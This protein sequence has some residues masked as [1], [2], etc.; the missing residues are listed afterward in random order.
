MIELIQQ[1]LDSYTASNPVEEEQAT[2]E[3]L[4]EIALYSLW[5]AGFFE[6]AAFQGGTS[7]RILH[8]LPRF[9]ED[10]DFILKEPDLNFKWS[11]YLDQLLEGLQEFGLQSEALDKSRMN[12][13]IKKA[14][15]KDNSVSNQLDLSF[16]HGHPDKKL[17][18]KL[19]I[20]VNPP[21]GS[22]FE[23]SYLDF[24]LDFEVCHQDLSSNFSLKVH[25]LL[26][27]PYLKGRDWYDF[28]WYVKQNIQPNL[29]HLQAALHQYGPWKGQTIDVDTEWLIHTLLEKVT[30]IDWS[31]ATQDVERF[32]STA[33]RESLKLWSNRFFT[34]KVESLG[35]AA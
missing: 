9:S 7:L 11:G 15:L 33:E 10:L 19:E 35:F 29:T 6:V 14:L 24:P 3:I 13:R 34:R 31:E 2:K 18:I 21:R 17:T 1:R 28:N 8:K 32:L 25:A 22:I 23:Y 4:Q 20:D 12:Q 26:C 30:T 16:Y 27:R 5:R